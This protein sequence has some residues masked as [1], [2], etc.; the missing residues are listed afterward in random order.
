[1][2]SVIAKKAAKGTSGSIWRTKA[3]IVRPNRGKL[4]VGRF[5]A[6]VRKHGGRP[7]TKGESSEFRRFSKDP[8]P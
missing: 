3:K 2:Q 6:L 7:L 5:D 4:A 8:Y 1:M